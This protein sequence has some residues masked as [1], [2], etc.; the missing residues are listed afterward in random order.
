MEQNIELNEHTVGMERKLE[1]CELRLKGRSLQEIAEHFGVSR[2]SVSR[3]FQNLGDRHIPNCPYR[4]FRRWFHRS[5]LTLPDLAEKVGKTPEYLEKALCTNGDELMDYELA[6][7]LMPITGLSLDLLRRNDNSAVKLRLKREPGQNSLD[8]VHDSYPVIAEAM[9][10]QGVTIRGLAKQIGEAY[11][12]VYYRLT[13]KLSGTYS[14]QSE[15]TSGLMEKI[16]LEL[17]LDTEN[18]FY[19]KGKET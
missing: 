8:T 15:A 9:Q 18:A 13:H 12:R 17:G 10:E 19:G 7:K 3:F 6:T 16:A 5:S 14:E 2:Q 1:I 11:A 4:A